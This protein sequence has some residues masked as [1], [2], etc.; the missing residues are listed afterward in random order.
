MAATLLPASLRSFPV[1]ALHADWRYVAQLLPTVDAGVGVF[2]GDLVGALIGALV[3]V[4]V[5]VLVGD[6]VGDLVLAF[7][8]SRLFCS[9][10]DICINEGAADVSH[11]L[12]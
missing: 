4:F 11:A 9:G 3:G 8:R 6:L 1:L 12:S 5:D 10:V 7:A 2:V